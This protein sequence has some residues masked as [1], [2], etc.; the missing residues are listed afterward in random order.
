MRLLFACLLLTSACGGPGQRA[1]AETPTA[2]TRRTPAEAP[3]ASNSDKERER[4]IQTNDEMT[5][6]QNAH[7]E[8]A[9]SSTEAPPPRPPGKAPPAPKPPLPDKK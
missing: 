8:A 7:R 9:S 4:M 2:T 1:L 3:A 6:A 5:D